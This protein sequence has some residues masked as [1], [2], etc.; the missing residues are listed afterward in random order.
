[1]TISFE[2]RDGEKEKSGGILMTSFTPRAAMS[3]MGYTT[4]SS[5]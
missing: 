1:M 2:G 4:T 3:R 5:G